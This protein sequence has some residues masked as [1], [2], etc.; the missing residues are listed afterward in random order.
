MINP[1]LVGKKKI[2]RSVIHGLTYTKHR[3]GNGLVMRAGLLAKGR[4]PGAVLCQGLKPGEGSAGM[5]CG[6]L[7]ARC[8]GSRCGSILRTQCAA[9]RD[10]CCWQA[11]ACVSEAVS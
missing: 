3:W 1:G 11:D 10:E 5:G 8:R 6:V 9:A 4:S 2:A 7:V